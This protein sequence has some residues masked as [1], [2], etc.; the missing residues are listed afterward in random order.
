[1]NS[2]KQDFFDFIKTVIPAIL[3]AWFITHFLIANAIVPTGSMESTIMT[4]SRLIGNRLAY[5]FGTMPERGDI[6]IFK[7]PDNESVYYVK[8][9]IGTP[10]DTIEIIPDVDMDAETSKLNMS[11]GHVYVNGHPIYEDYLNEPM[12]ATKYM[13]FEVPEG[14]YFCMGDNRNNSLDSRYWDNHFVYEDKIIAKVMF[15]YWKGFKTF[16]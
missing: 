10:G 4:G 15:Q 14:A 9:I 5:K 1:M 12:M 11:T 2:F 7:Y 8:R 13:K 3:L 16:N 6:V